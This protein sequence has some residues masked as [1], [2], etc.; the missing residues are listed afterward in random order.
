M[1]DVRGHRSS[2]ALSVAETLLGVALVFAPLALGTVQWWS[3]ATLTMISCAAALAA[4]LARP[5]RLPWP[6]LLAFAVTL[7]VGLQALP[8][9]PSLHRL[10][11]PRAAEL[12]G[13][14]AGW[15]ALSLDPAA[16]AREFA[17]LL[18]LSAVLFATS[19]VVTNSSSAKRRLGWVLTGMVIFQCV[20]VVGHKAV[21]TSAIY[22]LVKVTRPTL[23]LG[24]FGNGNHLAAYLTL[25]IPMVAVQALRT[26][27]VAIRRALWLTVAAACGLVVLTLSRS[28]VVGL[29]AALLALRLLAARGGVSAR[30]WWPIAAGG[31]VVLAV[32]GLLGSLLDGPRAGRLA[33]LL[34]PWR[35]LSEE[36]VQAWRD[37][38]RLIRD[39]WTTG[40]GR[41]AFEE[42]FP[43]YRVHSDGMTFTHAEN[44]PLQVLADLGVI[45]GGLLLAG[46]GIALYQAARREVSSLRTSGVALR[47]GAVAALCGITIHELGDFSLDAVGGVG[48]TAA[49]LWGFAVPSEGVLERPMR[50]WAPVASLGALAASVFALWF[51][52][53]HDLERAIAAVEARAAFPQ[54]DLLALLEPAMLRHPAEP[55]FPFM[56]GVDRVRHRRPQEALRHL[57]R[58]LALD[59][60][61]WRPHQVI[62]DALWQLGKPAQAVLEFRFAYQASG[63]NDRVIGALLARPGLR[64]E[65]QLGLFAGEDQALLA[66]LADYL[67]RA[68]RDDDAAVAARRLLALRPNDQ[69]SHRLLA[70]AALKHG[71]F[72]EVLT[73]TALLPPDDEEVLTQR[74]RALDRL[75]RVAEADELLKE[76]LGTPKLP[77]TVLLVAERWL[78]R[79]EPESALQ[80]LAK[81]P[82]KGMAPA[83]LGRLHLLRGRAFELQG[84]TREAILAQVDAARIDP[85]E[86]NR[87]GVGAAYERAGLLRP[88]YLAYR[89]LAHSTRTPSAEVKA[90]LARLEEQ[91]GGSGPSLSG[92]SSTGTPVPGILAEPAGGDDDE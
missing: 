87:L 65:D 34:H 37:V 89:A 30:R 58:A 44:A 86:V 25:G 61:A 91:V 76:R 45:V 70:K 39:F 56:A 35:L 38:P 71:R 69:P 12:L 67:G 55:W 4:A 68:G 41:G 36:K 17:R 2:G 75:G 57:N 79:K 50:P 16:S 62:A 1:D 49:V 31:G 19:R 21:D 23:V 81:I 51:G 8:L 64:I 78:D 20:A 54:G 43:S 9:P 29:I 40:V 3:L 26:S 63:Y 28:G 59:P 5:R 74:T 77:Q 52:W 85:T 18:G 24:T 22:G 14:R 46:W 88:A 32:L 33:T 80:I 84:K 92:G 90:R 10:L 66:R 73:E 13:E 83:D 11:T 53:T 6:I 82:Q 47:T 27:S 60:T 42:I 15:C 48:V 72:A 7:F